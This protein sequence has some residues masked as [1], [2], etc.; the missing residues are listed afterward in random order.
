MHILKYSAIFSTNF[1]DLISCDNTIS[2]HDPLAFTYRNM[3]PVD[4]GACQIF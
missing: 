3:G 1:F 2:M 4:L